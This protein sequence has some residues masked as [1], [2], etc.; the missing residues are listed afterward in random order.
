MPCIEPV[1]PENPVGKTKEMLDGVS[2]AHNVDRT[3]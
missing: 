3:E 2:P 1:H